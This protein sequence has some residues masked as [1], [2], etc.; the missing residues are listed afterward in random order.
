MHRPPWRTTAVAALTAL[1]VAGPL[2][3]PAVPVPLPGGLGPCVPGQCPAVY[4]PVSNGPIAGRDNGINIF[5]GGDFLVRGA[6][7]EAEGRVVTLG[8]FDQNKSRG[9]ALYNIGL[10]GVG[11]RVPPPDG[12]DWLTTGGSVTVAPGQRLDAE[13]GVVRH[14]GPAT[15]T[16]IG[17]SIEDPQ[18]AEPY[19]GLREEL[20]TASRC[21][22]HGTDG[23]GRPATGTAVNNGSETL[24]A[25]DGTSQLQVF[26]VD[27]DIAG[28]GGGQEG[29][30]FTGIPDGATVLV[31]LLGEARVINTYSGTLTDD[32]A[33]NRLRERLLWNIPDA[34]QVELK[35]TGQFQGSFLIGTPSSGTTVSLPGINGRFFTTGSLTHTSAA[36]GGGGQEFHNYPFN[37]DLPD[38]GTTPP[39]PPPP[40]VTGQVSVVKQDAGTHAVLPGARF[41]LW[42]ETNGM[43]GLQTTGA[44]PDTKVDGPCTTDAGGACRATVEPGTYY[45]QEIQAPPGY[46]VPAPGVFGPL[47]LTP[48]NAAT[49]VSATATDVKPEEPHGSIRLEKTDTRTKRP[50][51]GAVFELWRETNGKPGLQFNGPGADQRVETG[52][53]TDPQG[54]CT[55]TNLPLGTYYLL[56]TAMPEGY[57]NPRNPAFGP[58]QLTAANA[59]AGITAKVGNTP[60][61]H[62]K[63]KGNGKGQHVAQAARP[64]HTV[65]SHTVSGRR[66]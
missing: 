43:P 7:A 62:G 60:G 16:V 3:R 29:V 63:G 6:A 58:Y 25:G 49:G 59:A 54:H 8:S 27:F 24:F 37:G 51:Q 53:A 55:F 45:W 18:A 31:N 38:C 39:P 28:R 12:A 30:R 42:R 56:E 40:P 4:P 33:F 26:N 36:T 32:N 22:A 52:C 61:E 9:G 1:A 5:V 65:S 15:G 34:T 14:A 41:Q 66:R 46:L 57:L 21:Y 20:S 11:S 35:G 44:R 47:T 48:Q 19:E 13:R 23:L 17:R 64:S 2:A 50:L 10:A